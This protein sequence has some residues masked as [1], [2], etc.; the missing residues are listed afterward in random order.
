MGLHWVSVGPLLLGRIRP[1]AFLLG[2]IIH[3]A[4]ITITWMI[5]ILA[6][7]LQCIIQP[8]APRSLLE[9]HESTPTCCVAI[10]ARARSM[11][12]EGGQWGLEE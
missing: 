9:T 12:P 10:L 11:I 5:Q 7:L 8:A 2:R 1:A 4:Q 3:S 6:V